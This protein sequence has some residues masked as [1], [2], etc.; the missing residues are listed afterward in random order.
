MAVWFRR[1]SDG[2][3]VVQGISTYELIN[4][5][6]VL[7]EA[8]SVALYDNI[9]IRVADVQ[10]E[11]IDS[12]SDIAIVAGIATEVTNVSDNMDDVQFV[13]DN[14][15]VI[16][17]EKLIANVPNFI[18]LQ[19][20][21]T[22]HTTKVN[23]TEL[24]VGI[25]E[26]GGPFRYN[27]L[28]DK[29]TANG[30]TRVDTSVSLALQGSGSG[31]G[32]FERQYSGKVNVKWF[33]AVGDGVTDDTLAFTNASSILN[34]NIYVPYGDYPLTTQVTN[35]TLFILEQGTTITVLGSPWY[36]SRYDIASV[37]MSSEKVNSAATDP[38]IVIVG[39]EYVTLDDSQTNDN[40]IR[41]WWGSQYSD[42]NDNT[43]GRTAVDV[44]KANAIHYGEGDC[45]VTRTDA[46]CVR[47]PRYLEITSARGHN[48]IGMHNGQVNAGS[49]QVTLYGLGDMVLHDQG[50]DNVVMRG[51]VIIEY[52]NG[53]ETYGYK[54]DKF[55]YMIWSNG[56]GEIDGGFIG[57]GN[58]KVGMDLTSA[59]ISGS[60]AINLSQNQRINLDATAGD[61]TSGFVASANGS[62][63]IGMTSSGYSNILS[64]GGEVRFSANN[65]TLIPSTAGVNALKILPT[66]ASTSYYSAGSIGN[67]AY[68]GAVS[69]A[70]DTTLLSFRTSNGGATADRII[71]SFGSIRPNTDV[72]MDCGAA[73]TR[74][75]NT[76][77]K[78]IRPGDGTA[79]WT[80][81]T[82]S[83]EG[84]VTAVVGS[85]YT[86]IT[87]GAGTTLYVKESGT[88]NT[89]WV[90]K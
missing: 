12:P 71:I 53:A 17:A 4:N 35:D 33:G 40:T 78:N 55:G 90:A 73:A 51:Q 41:N 86:D 36:P 34:V 28:A 66:A 44:F 15:A 61:Q 50:F 57:R 11:L 3:W 89:G 9:E 70:T 23:L 54:A 27:H 25:P 69:D 37:T 49:D 60:A 72:S 16:G 43:K 59:S 56:T 26:S 85:M 88:G 79:L 82:G 10:D 2:I 20:V 30:G 87:G 5:T 22:A 8:P 52:F 31:L 21:D 83:P 84:V 24:H 63:S 13:S 38:G 67:F 7:Q 18:A 81:G 74:F 46:T 75:T 6:A 45:Y 14:I 19:A 1:V 48:N 58:I 76:F 29:A 77:S 62:Y 65:T 32:C 42:I 80:S 68:I 64:N 47:H 39:S